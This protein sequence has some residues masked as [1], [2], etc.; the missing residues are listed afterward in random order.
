MARSPARRGFLQG[1]AGERF[2]VGNSGAIAVVE[3]TGDHGCEYMTGG[4]VAVLGET[5]RNFAA[6]MSGGVAYVYDPHGKFAS[7][8]NQSGVDL[9]NIPVA[10]DDE[11]GRPRQRP[12]SVDDNGMGDLMR[13][14][15]ARLRILVE[16]H[17]LL[18]GSARA[19]QLL[20]DWDNTVKAFV[21]VMP[22][23]YRRALL[24]LKAEAEGAAR[25]IVCTLDATWGSTRSRRSSALTQT[26]SET[27]E[28]MER[29]ELLA[30]LRGRHR[31]LAAGAPI[32]QPGGLRR[33]SACWSTMAPAPR[34]SGGF[35]QEATLR[36][37]GYI[38]GQTVKF[39]FPRTAGPEPPART[40]RGGTRG[41]HPGRHHR[42]FRLAGRP[43]RESRDGPGSP[44]VATTGDPVATKLVTSL[45]RPGGN[46]TGNSILGPDLAEKCV[47]LVREV[48]PSSRR[49]VAL[50]N[51]RTTS[52]KPILDRILVGA[53]EAVAPQRHRGYL[54]RGRQCQQIS[55]P[56]SGAS[57]KRPLTR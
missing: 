53:V 31:R 33:R 15:A 22:K 13:H 36:E 30:G 21:K 54:G 28:G 18:T 42:N 25:G 27:R 20:D 14:D 45:A 4:V 57:Q 44:I 17:L 50:I 38:D 26:S 34:I 56:P 29:R 16:R 7:L 49:A 55:M 41:G 47:A 43:S 2:A 46:V 35:S 9:E 10:D 6:G 39:A 12:V 48:L 8:C 11:D 40:S 23:D 32:A 51:A 52:S 3:G 19:R 5:G 1:V 24:D 37:L